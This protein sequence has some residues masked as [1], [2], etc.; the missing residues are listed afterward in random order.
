VKNFVNGDFVPKKV[1]WTA[2]RDSLQE[3]IE[4]DKLFD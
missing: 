2:Y 4:I 3:A 1:A